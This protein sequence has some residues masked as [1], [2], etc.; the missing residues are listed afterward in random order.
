MK[1]KL[2]VL[3]AVGLLAGCGTTPVAQQSPQQIAAQ[4]CPVAT[5]TLAVAA[6]FEISDPKLAADVAVATPIVN[7]LCNGGAVVSFTSLQSFNT[8]AFPVLLTVVDT[9]PLSEA[10]KTQMKL[11]LGAAQTILASVLQGQAA[12]AAAAAK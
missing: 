3:L 2:F 11:D 7:A 6:S 4:V 1:M 8:T 12:A 10:Q 5:T 9:A